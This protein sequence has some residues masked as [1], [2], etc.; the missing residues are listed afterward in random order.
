MGDR[1]Q[2]DGVPVA[3]FAFF[4]VEYLCI[5][6]DRAKCAAE[7]RFEIVG[8]IVE[9]VSLHDLSVDLAYR[10]VRVVDRV[11]GVKGDRFDLGEGHGQ[12]GS[13]VLQPANRSFD[14][15]LIRGLKHRATVESPVAEAFKELVAVESSGVS[16]GE[17]EADRVVSDKLP[18]ED[19][20]LG[21]V[22]AVFAAVENA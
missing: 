13:A 12:Y 20:G 14:L 1:F 19:S 10:G 16:V 15:F 22:L 2:D 18:A 21:V 9:A 11:G 4:A 7:S 8:W 3:P 5:L 6:G 17:F